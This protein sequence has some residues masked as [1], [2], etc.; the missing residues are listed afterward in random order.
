MRKVIVQEFTTIDGFAAGPNG[1]IDFIAEFTAADPTAGEHVEDQLR[2]LETIDT[3]LLGAV[4]YQMFAEYWPSQTTDT[5]LIAD[6]LNATP[7]VVFSSHIE[8]APWGTWE[9]ARVVSGNAVEEVR[10]LR[11]GRGKDM[12]VWGSLSLAES[13]MTAGLVDEYRLWVCAVLLGQGRRLLTNS[14]TQSM[15]WLETKAYGDDVV[16]LRFEPTG[17]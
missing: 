3:I 14:G 6:A 5:E 2:F 16:S 7:K 15:R 13:L 12:V 10:R 4:T 9:Q 8:K 11:Q 1:E 17:T